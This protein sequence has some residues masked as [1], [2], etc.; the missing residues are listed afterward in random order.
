MSYEDL[1]T[2]IERDAWEGGYEECDTDLKMVTD[3]KFKSDPYRARHLAK[4]PPQLTYIS[5]SRP[6]KISRSST[7]MV[8]SALANSLNNT[9]AVSDI[10]YCDLADQ[11]GVSIRTAKRVVIA[12]EQ[13]GI[14]QITRRKRNPSSNL[15]NLL[16]FVT[17]SLTKVT[18]VSR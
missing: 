5:N 12:A 11:S 10:K 18:G 1:S 17:A 2:E 14:L 4:N 16:T 3:A 15:S 13:A 6:I 9:T 8:L 7:V